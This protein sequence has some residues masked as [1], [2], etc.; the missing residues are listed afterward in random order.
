MTVTG[1]CH[2]GAVRIEVPSAPEWLG[3]CNCSIC[4]RTGTLMAYYPDDGGVRIT[5][6]TTRYIWGDRMIALHH[7]PTCGCFTHWDS[8]GESHGKVGVNAR[9]LDGFSVSEGRV[10]FEERE[11]EVRFLDNAD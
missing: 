4:R 5:G 8:T 2:C 6:E 11:V 9:L 7:C 1:S 3:S 10:L